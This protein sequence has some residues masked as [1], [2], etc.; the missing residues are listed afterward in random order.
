[1]IYPYD[2]SLLEQ[3]AVP[4]TAKHV[5]VGQVACAGISGVVSSPGA[6]LEVRV[7]SAAG[8]FTDWVRLLVLTHSGDGRNLTR[9]TGSWWRYMLY[10]LTTPDNKAELTIATQADEVMIDDVDA[11]QA[12]AFGGSGVMP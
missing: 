6:F 3:I 9:L 4:S 10:T 7:T 2:M 12:V 1:M 8:E 5:H 11:S